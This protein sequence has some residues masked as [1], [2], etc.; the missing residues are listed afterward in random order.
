[1]DEEDVVQTHRMSL[2][3]ATEGNSAVCRSVGDL[4]C[5]TE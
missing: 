4:D 2:S 1:M 3:H 5:H